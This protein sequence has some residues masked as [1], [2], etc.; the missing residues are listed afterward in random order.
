MSRA[1]D[2][3]KLERIRQGK[4]EVN[5]TGVSE[6]KKTVSN[7]KGKFQISTKEKKFE[8]AGVARKKR[9]YVMYESKLGT[10]KDVDLQQLEEAKKKQKPKP[11][12]KG[13]RIE[14]VVISKVKRK[15]YL[16]NFQ[17][18]ETK[19]L[20]AK[21]PAVVVHTRLSNPISGTV[22]ERSYQKTSLRSTSAPKG[23]SVSRTSRQP[24][25]GEVSAT[26]YK[27]STTKVGRRGGA[28]GATSSIS[29][30][31]DVKTYTRGRK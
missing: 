17:Y 28:G 4:K 11:M 21:K 29:T 15:E 22:E 16:D 14:E 3:A 7:E 1:V 18:H 8:E 19:N 30:K 9:N 23:G 26:K 25:G 10:Q 12:K 24:V 5:I 6:N 27:E 13:Q 20:K 31:L 2:P